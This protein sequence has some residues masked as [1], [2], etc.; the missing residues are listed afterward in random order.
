MAL[1]TDILLMYGYL[2]LFA[3]VLVEQLGIPLPA[4]PVLLAAERFRPR[5]RSV[6]P[7]RW[8]LGWLP[9]SPPI[10]YGFLSGAG[11]GTT[12]CACSANYRWSR[13]P[14]SAAPRTRL[15][16]AAAR[17][18][19]LPSS[20]PVC[21]RWRR[22]WQGRMAWSLARFCSTT[23]SARRSGWACCWP[24]ADVLAICSSAI[25]ACSTGRADSPA[26]CSFWVLLDSLSRASFAA[27]WC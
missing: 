13:P 23:P 2:L 11:T 25:P 12:C 27:A 20:C 21:L 17:C 8:R 26:H 18:S 4:T 22:R 14:A 15:A 9:R 5:G 10:A 1:P 16:G 19:C 6:F 7:W 3:W 24:A